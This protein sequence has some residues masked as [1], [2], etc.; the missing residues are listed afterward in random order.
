VKIDLV[1]NDIIVTHGGDEIG[2]THRQAYRYG[3]IAVPHDA[4]AKTFAA[5][6]K[7]VME[8]FLKVF[9]TDKIRVVESLS[10]Q[11]GIQAARK[12]LRY[13]YFDEVGCEVGLDA[14]SSYRRTWSADAQRFSD[15]PVHDWSSNPADAFRYM[16]IRWQGVP[17]AAP[18]PDP[19]YATQIDRRFQLDE[20][21]ETAP[22]QSNRI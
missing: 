18:E 9:G 12:L 21:W 17:E 11:D 6:G 19:I 4:R 16:A 22:M 14:L 13:A 3:E 1:D 8:Q 5:K 20:L 10:L 7:S 15:K 2:A